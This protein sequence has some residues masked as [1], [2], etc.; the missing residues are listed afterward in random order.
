MTRVG[1]M[2]ELELRDAVI[3]ACDDGRYKLAARAAALLSDLVVVRS[4]EGALAVA[5]QAQTYALLALT[6]AVE[7]LDDP[8]RQ[9][10]VN[11]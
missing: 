11:A 8:I 5:A 6:E 10:G 3:S 2:N 7:L 4:P 9:A 1:A